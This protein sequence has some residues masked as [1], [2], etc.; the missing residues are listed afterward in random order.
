M[1]TAR[2]YSPPSSTHTVFSLGDH[3][4]RILGPSSKLP[5]DYFDAESRSPETDELRKHVRLT[6]E[7]EVAKFFKENIGQVAI[8]DANVSRL[9]AG[10]VS[11]SFPSFPLMS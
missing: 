4:R 8:Y 6:L 1:P 9:R 10:E 11:L 2:S 5:P 3:R 7:E